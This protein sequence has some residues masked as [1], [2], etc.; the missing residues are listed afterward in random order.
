[1]RGSGGEYR[2]RREKVSDGRD[3]VERRAKWIGGFGANEV[4]SRC[5]LQ[6]VVS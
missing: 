2:P 3:V 1:M 5:R 4:T 6:A